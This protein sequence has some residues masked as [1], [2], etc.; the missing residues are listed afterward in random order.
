MADNGPTANRF[1]VQLQEGATPEE[2]AA[3][4]M[5]EV[6]RLVGQ[7]NAAQIP[8]VVGPQQDLPEGMNVGQPVINWSSGAPALQVFD[9]N[10]LVS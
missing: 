9:G 1:Y 4:T 8:I 2:T 5:Q 7:L 10:Q 6:I 3:R